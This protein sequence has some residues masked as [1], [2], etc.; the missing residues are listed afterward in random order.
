MLAQGH[1]HRP[2]KAHQT[3][4]QRSLIVELSTDPRV[5]VSC[6]GC[7]VGN[8]L[9]GRQD[10]VP[11]ADLSD[12]DTDEGRRALERFHSRKERPPPLRTKKNPRPFG[13]GH[14]VIDQSRRPRL[15]D[16]PFLFQHRVVDGGCAPR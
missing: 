16:V 7:A 15:A 6:F 4:L 13:R 3:N 2:I 14:S 5:L 8:V 12:F 11:K 1:S 9:K 10:F